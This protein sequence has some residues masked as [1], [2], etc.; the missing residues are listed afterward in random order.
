MVIAAVAT[1]IQNYPDA[2]AG[3]KAAAR[4]INAR[5]GIKGRQIEITVCNQQSNA[6]VAAACARRA[7]EENFTAVVGE[8]HN[9]NAF[10]LPILTA[11]KIP[12]IGLTPFGTV[13][14]WSSPYSFPLHAG[15][16]GSTMGL[17]YAFKQLGQ[18]RIAIV[19]I[20]TATALAQA[21][22]V[23]NTIGAA[24][25]TYAGTIAIPQGITDYGPYAQRLREMRAD[26][27]IIIM[28]PAQTTPLV[29]TTASIGY[30]VRWGH[31]A[32][33]IGE[34]EAASMGSLAEGMLIAGNYPSYHDTQFAGI[35]R[36]NEE[37]AAAGYKDDPIYFRQIG[38]NAWLSVYA[39][40]ALAAT[41][42]GEI[43]NL[44]LTAAA[45]RKGRVYKL[46]DLIEWT[47]GDKGPVAFPRYTNDKQYF[48]TIK[49]GKIVD[50]T[51]KPLH[52]LKLQHFVR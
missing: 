28:G 39:V 24:K 1:P 51:V 23:K 18:K 4:A 30:R 31:N 40:Q 27:A 3:A 35:R 32:G 37:M 13:A 44:T 36:F 25:L 14:D 45:N 49:D 50:S 12:S 22:L 43:N 8:A 46:F 26:A 47:P 38:I 21:K 19:P 33:S 34:P 48:L 9:L 41:M 42:T 6:N 52:P 2:E 20:E 7:A 15:N 16:P 10:T 29:R 5:G 11:N 17:V